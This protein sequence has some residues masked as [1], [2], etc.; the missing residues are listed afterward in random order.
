MYNQYRSNK[1]FTIIGSIQ[2]GDNIMAANI[3]NKQSSC[4]CPLTLSIII[5]WQFNFVTDA[6]SS[7]TIDN[8]TQ[9]YWKDST[10]EDD[11]AKTSFVRASSDWRSE[12]LGASPPTARATS[13]GGGW[14]AWPAARR[15]R[16]ATRGTARAR[17]PRR[18]RA[19]AA[20]APAA[21][22]RSPCSLRAPEDAS[23]ATEAPLRPAK[24]SLATARAYLSDALH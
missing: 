21:A 20:P 7:Q 10:L 9:Y 1:L 6:T 3:T 5:I 22:A 15:A 8:S 19:A 12:G 17:R 23:A 14:A 11:S 18:R 16:R 4:P 2:L 24:A 13:R